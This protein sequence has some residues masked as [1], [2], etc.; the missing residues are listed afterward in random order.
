MCFIGSY[1][2]LASQPCFPVSFGK[3]GGGSHE[4]TMGKGSRIVEIPRGLKDSSYILL[5]PSIGMP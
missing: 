3:V 4:T 5:V 1:G 2:R